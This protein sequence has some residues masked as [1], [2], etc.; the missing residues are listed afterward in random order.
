MTNTETTTRREV[1]VDTALADIYRRADL[2]SHQRAA[3]DS[4]F[5]HYS[6]ARKLSR[7]QWD[8]TSKQAREAVIAKLAAGEIKSWDLRTVE[9]AVERW[10][11]TDR[12]L[13]A[14]VA[15]RAPF[16]AEYWAKP[17]NRFFLV[18]GGHIHAS[19][20]CAGG[21]IRPTTQVGWLPNLSGLTEADAVAAHGTILCSHCFP[22]APVEWTV[23]LAK[24]GQCPGVD[25]PATGVT[26]GRG[27]PIKRWGACAGC[28]KNFTVNANGRPRAHK[29]AG[30]R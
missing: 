22:S 10:A 17:W 15:E 6:G 19:Q 23:G 29:A 8:L 12:E 30:V 20:T 21:T 2:V 4:T 1:T 5:R 24:V 7:Y 11:E 26:V 16:D 9:S 28:G 14:L 18:L 13:D 27:W 3:L 25:Q